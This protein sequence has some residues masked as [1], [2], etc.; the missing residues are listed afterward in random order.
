MLHA[1]VV[2]P[3]ELTDD[4]VAALD[5][6]PAA[7][8]LSV[9]PLSARSETADVV[10]FDLV[11]EGANAVI[12]QLRELDLEERGSIA[13]NTIGVI[14]SAAAESAEAAVPGRPEDAVVWD[15]LAA[16]TAAESE[17]SWSYLTFFSLATMLAAIGAVLDQPIVIV[18]AMVL[19]PEFGAI[20]ALCF[21][22]VRREYRHVPPAG[23][24]L[25]LGYVS[26]IT[27]AVLF[28]LI[29]YERG[30]I[31]ASMLSHRPQTEFMLHPG[32]WSFV[33]ALLAG[34]AGMLSIT[35]EK[36]TPLVGVFISVATIPAAG[37]IAVA[38]ALG[39]WSEVGLSAQQLGLNLAGLVVAGIVTLLVQ[40]ILWTR[41]GLGAPVHRHGPSHHRQLHLPG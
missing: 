31:D 40:R 8:D 37:N 15:E 16:E 34:V 5:A 10:E 1:R 6:S 39:E 2:S 18:G 41:F 11:R 35:S 22:V 17:L 20:A 4:V 29:V 33:V 7:F 14:I 9:L 12:E 13:V 32:H 38:V 30:W 28:S 24:K 25:V 27:S 21:G 19:G 3:P 23:G 36:S 26:A